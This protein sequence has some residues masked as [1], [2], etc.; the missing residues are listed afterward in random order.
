MAFS[1]FTQNSLKHQHLSQA[2][3][4]Q[5]LSIWTK[6]AYQ[7]LQIYSILYLCMYCTREHFFI[8]K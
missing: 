2:T 6:Q 5:K 7:E 1:H 8:I 3:E 4:E